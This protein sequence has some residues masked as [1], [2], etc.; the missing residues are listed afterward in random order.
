MVFQRGCAHLAHQRRRVGLLVSIHRVFRGAR[1]SLEYPWVGFGARGHQLRPFTIGLDRR[2][3]R[4]STP[5]PD[6]VPT[7][8]LRPVMTNSSDKAGPDIS[9]PSPQTQA[10]SLA[11]SRSPRIRLRPPTGNEAFR[12]ISRQAIKASAAGWCG[13][14]SG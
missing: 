8:A 7:P 9:G 6:K 1:C 13:T 2:L 10:T 12:Y 4:I 3:V 14:P 5:S 11:L